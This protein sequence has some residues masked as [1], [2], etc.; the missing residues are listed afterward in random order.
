MAHSEAGKKCNQPLRQLNSRLSRADS[1]RMMHSKG[2]SPPQQMFPE[3]RMLSIFILFM[4]DLCVADQIF[5]CC[6]QTCLVRCCQGWT[7][8]LK[9]RLPLPSA[10]QAP[11]PL[12]ATPAA[13]RPWA[14]GKP[15]R[16][17]ACGS[18][19]PD[20]LRCKECFPAGGNIAL[21]SPGCLSSSLGRVGPRICQRSGGL[22]ALHPLLGSVVPGLLVPLHGWHGQRSC[23]YVTSVWILLSNHVLASLFWLCNVQADHAD[24]CSS[25]TESCKE[26]IFVFFPFFF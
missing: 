2:F 17:A 15:R 11:L 1:P 24:N 21:T 5:S 19:S 4:Q 23:L 12:Q 8:A 7:R 16:C 18:A 9:P 20:R 10:A 26:D 25:S 6:N 22:E 3:H 13:W 14:G